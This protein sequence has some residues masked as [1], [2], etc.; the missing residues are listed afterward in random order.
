M[1]NSILNYVLI[2]DDDHDICDLL[3]YLLEKA[4]YETNKVHDGDAVI[5]SLM[6]REPNLLLLDN[7]MPGASGMDILAHTHLYYPQLPVIMITGN[8]GIFDAVS[9]IKAGARDYLTKPFDN[10]RVL[11][12]VNKELQILKQMMG[13]HINCEPKQNTSRRIAAEMGNSAEIQTLIKSI[14]SVAPTNFSVII[15]GQSGTG[16]ELVAKNIHLA[17]QRSANSFTPIDC[18]AIPDTL[19]ENELFGHEKGSYTGAD[20]QRVGRIEATE[21]GTL[22][23]DEIV[24][25]SL[26]SQS[27]LLRVLQERVIYRVGS[28][29][30]IPV[31]IRILVAS[32]EDLLDAVIK[33]KF[34]EDLYFRL[35]EFTIRIPSLH[36]RPAD[37]LFLAHRY[38]LETSS[39]L[40]KSIPPLSSSAI[41]E[42]L[43]YSWPGNVR[44]LRAV[45]RRAVLLAEVEI[46]V[47]ELSLPVSNDTEQ[48][49][50]SLDKAQNA[51]CKVFN[52]DC[53]ECLESKLLEG[54]TL[55][56]M[57][58]F[59][60]NTIIKKMMIRTDN[61]KSETSRR[62]S[63]DY[64]TL[65][66]K[67]KKFSL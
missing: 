41:N 28:I 9:A 3:V 26:S 10:A 43:Q 17:S 19:I 61:N 23:L 22:F 12:L 49:T 1:N 20:Q 25:L 40:G 34:R 47:S 36:N 59:V 57:E 14:L 37:I 54:M 50:N 27:K 31:N 8:G 58:I 18:G 42:L 67:I 66:S 63:I 53:L 52:D 2:A 65:L 15:Q 5:S 62:L 44:E 32:N 21:G 16:K 6:K 13:N 55:K 38:I 24:N 11:E 60:S 56:E 29:K 45:I 46:G 30:P 33:G 4:G 51:S 39:E 48:L 7:V 35:N 64:K